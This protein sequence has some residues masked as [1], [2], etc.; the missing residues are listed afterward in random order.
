MRVLKTRTICCYCQCCG[1]CSL[2]ANSAQTT[3]LRYF[4]A[5]ATLL[6]GIISWKC[7]WVN[8][9][10]YLSSRGGATIRKIVFASSFHVQKYSTKLYLKNYCEMQRNIFVLLPYHATMLYRA[11]M[12]FLKKIYIETNVF[13]SIAQFK[14]G[15][16]ASVLRMKNLEILFW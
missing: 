6:L 8:R 3:F 14:S 4:L 11:R 12:G 7:F 13:Y 16:T 15:A 1:K 2:Y 10:F 5:T 9:C